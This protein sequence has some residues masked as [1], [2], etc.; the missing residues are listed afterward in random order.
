M[1]RKFKII[2]AV[3][4]FLQLSLAMSI[5]AQPSMGGETFRHKEG[6]IQFDLPAGW[7]AEPNGDL[8]QVSVPD[9]S[10]HVTFWVAHE[11]SMDAA[12]QALDKELGQVLSNIKS[13][14]A[15]EK[16]ELNGMPVV[17]GSGSAEVEGA[18]IHWS[19]HIIQAKRPVLVL[20]FGAPGLYQ[21]HASTI[22][23][24]VNSIKP[25]EE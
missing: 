7:N 21:K 25:T 19:I 22:A 6:G 5:N 11:D 18:Q 1:L 3:L 10:L 14:G 2:G 15:P 4:L 24:F 9:K 16:S 17:S 13:D 23:K 20:A 12:V 8:L